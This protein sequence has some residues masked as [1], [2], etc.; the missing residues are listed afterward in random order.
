MK[1]LSKLLLILLLAAVPLLAYAEDEPGIYVSYEAA[2]SCAQFQNEL[3]FSVEGQLYRW[4]S[5]NTTS[6]HVAENVRGTLLGDSEH[7]YALDI[8]QNMLTQFEEEDGLFVAVKSYALAPDK[9]TASDERPKRIYGAA[10]AQEN[11]YLMTESE[12]PL[13]RDIL[14]FSLESGSWET[15]EGQSVYALTAWQRGGILLARYELGS[16]GCEILQY[17]GGTRKCTLLFSLESIQPEAMA[18]ET[19]SGLLYV[20]ENG[21]VFACDERRPPRSVARLEDMPSPSYACVIDGSYLA[22]QEDGG[23]LSAQIHPEGFQPSV[24][25]FAGAMSVSQ[26]DNPAFSEAHP[27][28]TIRY[29]EDSLGADYA[30]QL[31]TNTN[32]AD[33]YL[34]QTSSQGYQAIVSKGYAYDL[35]TNDAL[36]GELNQLYPFLRDGMLSSS[37]KLVAV[38]IKNISAPLLYTYNPEAWEAAEIGPVPTTVEALMDACMAFAQRDDLL[39]RGWRFSLS[40]E[41][42]ETFKRELLQLIIETYLTETLTSDGY[43][44][45][46][47]PTFHRLLEK[48]EQTLPAIAH[49]ADLTLPLPAAWYTEDVMPTC[50]LSFPGSDL[51]PESESAYNEALFLP[52]SI[53]KGAT[54]VIGCDVTVLVINAASP[55]CALALEYLETYMCNLDSSSKIQYMPNEEAPVELSFYQEDKDVLLKKQTALEAALVDASEEERMPLQEQIQAV[56]LELEELEKQRYSIGTE[57]IAKYKALT[58]FMRLTPYTG[59]NF[60]S[61]TSPELVSLLNQYVQGAIDKEGFIRRYE[62]M[63]RMMYLE[64][65]SF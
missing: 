21:I 19:E 34:F 58:P 8:Q 31:I 64:D 29:R 22:L 50:L 55:N 6:E 15:L 43:P 36:C 2:D 17:D 27:D 63:A 46:D 59:L 30:T 60:Y 26:E 40:S 11:V 13:L 47:T 48:Y 20:Q 37:G 38:P 5:A 42:E 28:V 39:E 49:M 9:V 41:N 4:N 52:L 44:T 3:F 16:S 35:S 24:L 32:V 10:M 33:I 1:S 61:S 23:V 51:L 45:M 57:T 12:N 56:Q 62:Q 18:Y 65:Q 25:T 14:C 53:E 7:L 54:P